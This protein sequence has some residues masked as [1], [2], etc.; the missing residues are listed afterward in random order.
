[1]TNYNTTLVNVVHFQGKL[2]FTLQSSVLLLAV[3]VSDSSAKLPSG[4]GEAQAAAVFEA[5]SEWGLADSIR[6]MCFDTVSKYCLY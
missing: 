5:V 2:N 4:T 6:A 1:M 3:A